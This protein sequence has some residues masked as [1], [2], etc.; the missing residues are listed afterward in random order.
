MTQTASTPAALPY[1]RFSDFYP[2]YLD[3]HRNR[4]CRR[5]HFVG[6]SLAIGLVLAAV[7]SAQW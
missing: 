7:I 2:Y 4:T 3:E 5:L 1:A 6:S